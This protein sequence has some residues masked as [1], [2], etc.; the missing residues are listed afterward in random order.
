[1]KVQ[2]ATFHEPDLGDQLTAVVFLVDER[3][4]NLDKWPDS[5]KWFSAADNQ[6]D[7]LPL[8][9]IGA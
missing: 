3:V 2:H 1:M 7:P 9:F 4:W 5:S 8:V 6:T